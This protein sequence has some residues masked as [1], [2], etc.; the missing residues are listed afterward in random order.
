[1]SD[2]MKRAVA[3]IFSAGGIALVLLILVF[4][5]VLCARVNLRWDATRDNLYSLSD[6]TRDIL[7]TLGSDVTI[8]VF[9]SQDTVNL[10]LPLKAYAKRV[11][12]FLSEYEYAGKGRVRVEFYDP[13]VDSEEEEWAQKY[14]I[15]GLSLQ[16][17]ETVYFGLVAMAADQEETIAY[18]DPARESY[19]EYDITRII[20]RVQSAKKLKK[21]VSSAACRFSGIGH[22]H[23]HSRP[24]P[25]RSAVAVYR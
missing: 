15:Q 9:Y 20:T 14:G 5:N 23:G 2:K 1:M 6:G 7:S 19:L 22:A 16:T 10:P 4:A 13:Q 11:L 18:L 21:E 12:D 25:G 17:G 3:S 8:K 24:A